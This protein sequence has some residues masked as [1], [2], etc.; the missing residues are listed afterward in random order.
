MCGVSGVGVGSDDGSTPFYYPEPQKIGNRLVD[1]QVLS[2]PDNTGSQEQN[3]ALRVNLCDTN[4]TAQILHISYDIS[5]S[6]ENEAT[7]LI[8]DIFHSHAG[9]LT[10]IF[11]KPSQDLSQSPKY[12]TSRDLALQNSLLAS[13]PNGTVDITSPVLFMP[14]QYDLNVKILG[15]DK[16]KI[17][18]DESSA[19]SFHY[20]FSLH[21]RFFGNVSYD[22]QNFTFLIIPFTGKVHNFSFDPAVPKLAFTLSANGTSGTPKFFDNAI[23]AVYIPKHL[24]QFSGYP[25]PLN[26]TING[27]PVISEAVYANAPTDPMAKDDFGIFIDSNRAFQGVVPSENATYKSDTYSFSLS[28]VTKTT[29]KYDA[30]PSRVQ[31]FVS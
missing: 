18:Y 20:L 5:I 1:I 17:T 26:A 16:D 4:D 12:N 7:P 2:Y 19:P 30:I 8:H 3:M 29:I 23:V 22:N 15:L 9:P 31:A 13:G 27:I 14:G 11:Q 25:T 10:L 24:N 21:E 28:P 6:P